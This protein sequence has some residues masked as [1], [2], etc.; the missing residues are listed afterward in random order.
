MQ[1]KL[2][3]TTLGVAFG[4]GISQVDA[5]A[6]NEPWQTN[7]RGAGML[8]DPEDRGA[9]E[10]DHALDGQHARRRR[11]TAVATNGLSLN[12]NYDVTSAQV[13]AAIGRPL[14]GGAATQSVNW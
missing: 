9:G 3:E 2:P 1:A 11:R 8:H 4:T 14:P 13:Q 7:F 10:C 6:V 5:C 12:A